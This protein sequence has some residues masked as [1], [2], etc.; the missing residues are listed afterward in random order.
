MRGAGFI[1]ADSRAGVSRDVA[2]GR[3]AGTDR[4]VLRL[5]RRAREQWHAC[6]MFMIT[7]RPGGPYC[8]TGR[9]ERPRDIIVTFPVSVRDYVAQPDGRARRALLEREGCPQGGVLKTA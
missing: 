1:P 2:S 6:Q 8:G 9:H 7:F 4:R 3:R 5:S